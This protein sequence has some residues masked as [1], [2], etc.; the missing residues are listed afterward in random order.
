MTYRAWICEACRSP[1]RFRE[2]IWDC[3]GCGKEGCDDCF[4]RYGHCK[5]C[6]TGKS[7]EQLRLAANATGDFDFE[8]EL[9]ANR[10]GTGPA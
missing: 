7:D 4:D 2:N 1:Q 9:A 8:P 6:S 10:P 5:A 3:P